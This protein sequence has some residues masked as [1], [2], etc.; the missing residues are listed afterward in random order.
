MNLR[1]KNI[2]STLKNDFERYAGKCLRIRTKDGEIAPLTL[3]NAQRYIHERLTDQLRE[4]GRVRAIILKGRQQGCST[5]TEARYFWR[6]THRKGVRVFILTHRDDA[7]NNLYKM[8]KRF[9]KHCPPLVR[10]STSVSNSK[11]LHFDVLDSSYGIGTAKAEGTGRSD[12][13]QY[14]HGSEV[15]FWH[16]ATSHT[17]GVMQAIPDAPGT[18]VILESTANG[19]G[20]YFHQ[21]WQ[22]AESGQ[23]D[24]QAIF[25]PWFWQEEYRKEV[26]EDFSLTQ[27][28]SEYKTLYGLSDGQIAWRRAKIAELSAD[29]MDGTI[30][31][32]QEYPATPAEAFQATGEDTLINTNVISEAR[33][34][35]I[36][37][38]GALVIGVDP[39]RFGS[40][41]SSFI[42]RQGR[43][44]FGLVS[45]E[46][47]D[48]MEIA[49]ICANLLYDG[50]EIHGNIKQIDKMFVDVV[51]L[52]AGVYD[53]L[54]ELGFSSRVIAVNGASSPTKKDKYSNKR[55]EMWAEMN[56]W[57][58]SE[59]G[60][61][62]PDLDSLHSD[63]VAP[64]YSYDSNG[65]L[66]IEKKE[67]M[68]KRGIRSPDEAD[69]LSLTFAQPVAN[70]ELLESRDR[71]SQR[72]SKRGS[73]WSA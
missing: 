18:E 7:T 4:T 24:F 47:K 19:V 67:D 9:L 39:A 3:N 38:G 66:K 53:R 73:S 65:R 30:G 51:G 31:F 5:Y 60:V 63:L 27:E 10:P 72:H 20:N 25:I 13:I 43:K 11:E 68:K 41:R 16:N 55:A 46:K 22:M 37:S 54:I 64:K 15:A 45:Y 48:T 23:S 6:V 33:K 34:N 71:Y 28:E 59:A 2:R 69:A 50:V 52:G 29:G 62:V 40:D 1:E 58:K 35:E 14:F 8:A 61:D 32:K 56:I 21:Q 36:D 42:F 26:A 57:F 12:T 70:P 44:A 17:K 49:G